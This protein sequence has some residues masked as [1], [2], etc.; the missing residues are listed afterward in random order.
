MASEVREG[1]FGKITGF[2]YT[3]SVGGEKEFTVKAESAVYFEDENRADFV[4]ANV[5]FFS[6]EGRNVVLTTDGGTLSTDSNDIIANG[7]VVIRSSD[8]YTAKTDKLFYNAKTELIHTK[9][10]VVVQGDR[11]SMSGR[12]LEMNI[13]DQKLELKNDV[14]GILVR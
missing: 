6:K 9:D 5:A 13:K 7:N 12:G 14:R 11:F 1:A 10:P 3:R 2:T 4:K 8:G